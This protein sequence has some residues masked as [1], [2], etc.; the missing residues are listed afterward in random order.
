[1]SLVPG[2]DS[3]VDSAAVGRRRAA[4]ALHAL[5]ARDREW[6]LAQLPIEDRRAVQLLLDELNELGIPPDAS[7]LNEALATSESVE[8]ATSH[9][10]GEPADLIGLTAALQ[11]EAPVLQ[12]MFLSAM[13]A[14]QQR[15]IQSNW[16]AQFQ[17]M[18]S[19]QPQSHWTPAL[20][21]A[22]AESWR[23]VAQAHDG[24]SK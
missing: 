16:D 10:I 9:G 1:M 11:R 17:A 7:I 19:P 20:C 21:Q 14:L 8:A 23:A 18:P 5:G 22:V 2:M 6:L 24:A 13:D 15:A 3:A 4:L 12:G